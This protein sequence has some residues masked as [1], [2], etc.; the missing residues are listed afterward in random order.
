MF[1]TRPISQK[2][3]KIGRRQGGLYVLNQFKESI[4][5]PC[6]VDLS[7]FCL[8]SSSSAFLFVTFSFGSCFC[9]SFKNFSAMRVL[10]T[11]DSHDITDCSGCKLTKFSALPFY[12]NIYSSL[13][14]FDLVHYDV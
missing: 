1:C 14:P 8:S 6:S 11:L 3:I 4:V 2:V 13:S 5:A 7:S 9:I 12:K 10:G